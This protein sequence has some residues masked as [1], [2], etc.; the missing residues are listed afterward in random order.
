MATTQRP[1]KHSAPQ[2]ESEEQTSSTSAP[3]S[4]SCA[5]LSAGRA[6]SAILFLRLF[7][8]TLLFTQAI[9]KSQQYLWLEGEYPSLWGLSGADVVSFVGVLEAVAGALLA[10]GLLTRLTSAVMTVVMV[11]AAFL[12]FPG[13]SFD[14][15]ELKVVYAG[16]YVFLLIAGGGRYSLDRLV[17]IMRQ[18]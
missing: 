11:G 6:D 13:Q 12:L 3:T 18:N 7:I 5:S 2:R 8:G 16:I 9:T 4:E 15:A 10:V 17:C 14:E 1:H